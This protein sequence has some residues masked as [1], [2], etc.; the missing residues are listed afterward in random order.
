MDVMI[1]NKCEALLLK[2][3]ERETTT[4]PLRHPVDAAWAVLY[5]HSYYLIESCLVDQ[6]IRKPLK[7]TLKKLW[8]LAWRD[9]RREYRWSILRAVG[10]H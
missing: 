2:C 3:L 1:N 6:C 9:L 4:R 5:L 7:P 10:K 8:P